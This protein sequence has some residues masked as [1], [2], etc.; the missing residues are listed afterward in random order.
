[1]NIFPKDA[2]SLRRFIGF[3][4]FSREFVENF[5]HTTTPLYD[6]MTRCLRKNDKDPYIWEDIHQKAFDKLCYQ[7]S[8]APALAHVRDVGT[9]ILR[10]DASKVACGASLHQIQDG[11]ERLV[12][13]FSRKM[14]P[15]MG[16]KCATQLEL[17]AVAA[18]VHHFSPI[19]T[20]RSC[21]F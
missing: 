10:T 13:Y 14:T 19:L 4:N 11:K 20:G 6:L 9:V 7:L 12:G 16:R 5:A 2:E 15:A 1:M 18:A 17:I 3:A 8:T 21:D